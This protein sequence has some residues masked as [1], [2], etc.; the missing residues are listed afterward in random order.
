MAR[1]SLSDQI[2]RAMWRPISA[3]RRELDLATIEVALVEA[4][5]TGAAVP[6]A[7]RRLALVALT[8]ALV[9]VPAGMA[10]A[11]E[12]SVPGDLLFPVKRVTETVRSWIDEDV[13]AVH[14]IEELEK[15]IRSDVAADRIADQ[16]DRAAA[17]IDRLETDHVLDQRLAAV[18]TA[19]TDVRPSDMADSGNVGE[20]SD[21]PPSTAP[22][23]DTPPTSEHPSGSATTTTSTSVVDSTT[24]SVTDTTTTT[25][26]DT[27]RVAGRVLAGP[28]CP[29]QRFPP[30]P[31]C[32]DLPVAGAVLV[33]A[34]LDGKELAR[35][36]ST[37]EGRFQTRLPNGIY[38]LV[39][40]PFDGLL[41]TAPSQEFVLEG[42]PVDLQVG[43]DTGI[44]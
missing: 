10:L 1:P 25:A 20:A 15:M 41:G 14:R 24:T 8:A 12:S 27:F 32:A 44:R 38:L 17:A 6:R 13:V 39:P 22:P 29:V 35:V 28:T 34:T 19:P 9:I 4:D 2:R 31:D 43:Y 7:R 5:R 23:V 33:V 36:E 21:R 42:A 37:E 26:L 40:Q 30:D 16:V 3:E 18:A 11:A